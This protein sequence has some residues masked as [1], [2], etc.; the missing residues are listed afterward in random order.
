MIAALLFQKQDLRLDEIPIPRISENE[1]LIKTRAASICGTDL[2][3]Y[4]NGYN[5][6]DVKNPL[7]LGHELSGE[8]SEVGKNLTDFKDSFGNK[9]FEGARVAVAPNIGCGICDLCVSGNTHLCPDYKALGIN[10]HGGFAQYFRVPEAAIRQGNIAFLS[11]NISFEDAACAEPLS[12]VYNGFENWHIKPGDSVLIMGAGP[13]GIMHLMLARMVGAGQLFVVD[14]NEARL[15]E[16]REIIP[17]CQILSL[18]NLKQSVFEYTR[19]KGVDI[20]VTANPSPDSQALSLQL[21]AIGG[22]VIFFGGI[23]SSV[24]MPQ[25]DTN[26]IHYR[27]L[28]VTGT[29]RQS[30]F[31]FRKILSLIERKLFDLSRIITNRYSI[32][33]AT[34]AFQKASKKEGIKHVFTFK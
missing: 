2:R 13:I 4:Q 18:E 29:T 6:V 23:P 33:D 32:Q 22:R 31:H 21:M 19:G 17:E 27:Q 26:L 20:C 25:L 34:L 1:V 7:I 14:S 12:C 11:D 9:F 15:N 24:P 5:G 30:I 28:K 8:I 16:A 3:M 10:L